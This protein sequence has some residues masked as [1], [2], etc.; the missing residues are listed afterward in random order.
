MMGKAREENLNV[1]LHE[2]EVAQFVNGFIDGVTCESE[3]AIVLESVSQSSHL[4]FGSILSSLQK[5]WQRLQNKVNAQVP[6]KVIFYAND[7]LISKIW[8][9]QTYILKS[10]L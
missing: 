5:L 9:P 6:F 2:Y 8:L 4:I 1:H 7:S 3:S 10:V